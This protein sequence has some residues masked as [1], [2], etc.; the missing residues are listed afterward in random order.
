MSFKDYYN[1]LGLESNKVT[2]DEIK[3]AYRE[4]AKRYHPDMHIGDN[5]SEEKFKDINEAYRVLSDEKARR[6]Y[7]RNWTIYQERKRKIQSS[8]REEKKS[9]KEKLLSILF[10]ITDTKKK[11]QVKKKEKQDGENIDTEVDVNV[12]EAFNGTKKKLKLLT[13]NGK[14]KVFDLDVP[15]GIQNGDKIRFVGQGKPGK[16]GGK[17]GDLIVRIFIKD[18]KEFKINGADIYK[19]VN[20]M[21]WE[22]AL[23]TKLKINSIDG[24][25]NLVIPKGT[26]SGERFTIKER[27]YKF[28][29]G[30]RG[31]FYVITKIVV[32][33]KLNK[34]EEELYIKLKEIEN[35]RES[36][37]NN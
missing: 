11:V 9:F 14:T 25:I 13:V 12:L 6:K 30:Q 24:E 16:N 18:T 21:P 28:G 5:I 29:K 19:E 3:I 8:T 26:G 32:P 1:I 33:K 34:Q 22:A 23:G 20:I 31:N 15:A 17:N 7:N 35:I 10:G 36:A 4:Q 2:I 27:G 37:V